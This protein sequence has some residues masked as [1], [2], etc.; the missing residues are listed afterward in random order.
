MD[1]PMELRGASQEKLIIVSVDGQDR[2]LYGQRRLLYG[3][4]RVGNLSSLEKLTIVSVDGQ[5]RL[6]YGQRRLLC[7]RTHSHQSIIFHQ[8]NIFHPSK[9]FP[10][11]CQLVSQTVLQRYV[12][13]IICCN[14]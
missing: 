10:R 3:L 6:L 4:E 2:L 8:S 9:R 1:G 5:F 12:G 14:F 11:T 7:I 13:N